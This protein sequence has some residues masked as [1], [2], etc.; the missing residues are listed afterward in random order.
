MVSIGKKGGEAPVLEDSWGRPLHTGGGS[1]HAEE[2]GF[3]AGCGGEV[4]TAGPEA[5]CVSDRV[6]T[7]LA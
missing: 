2:P 7:S 1:D 3:L 4:T 5:E 6:G